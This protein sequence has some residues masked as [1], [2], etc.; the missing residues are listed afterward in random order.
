MRLEPQKEKSN[1]AFQVIVFSQWC[2]AANAQTG[3][4]GQ[5]AAAKNPGSTKPPLIHWTWESWD[6]K[7]QAT[8]DSWASTGP[9]SV[10]QTGTAI[11]Q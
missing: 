6:K 7:L 4:I 2:S 8:A 9:M 11:I 1:S 5:E 3:R 10:S